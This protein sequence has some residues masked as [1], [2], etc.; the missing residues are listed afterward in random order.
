M[1][2][3]KAGEVVARLTV[4]D[5]DEPLTVNALSKFTIIQGNDRGFFNISTD[6]NGMDGIITTLKALDFEQAN[7][8]SLL[9]M[10]ENEAPFVLPFRTST[11]TVTITVLDVNEPPVFDLPEKQIIIYEDQSVGSMI[12][13]YTATDPDTDRAQKIRYKLRGDIAN[14]LEITEDTGHIT[15]SSSLDREA[16]FIRD[17]Q[18]KVLVLAFDDGN[19]S[20]YLQ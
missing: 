16:K 7:S 20:K 5:K 12:S 1:K 8:F 18:Y 4:T 9:I 11:A 13:K 15:I 2:E 19:L 10:V 3:N 6:H 14:W 17:G